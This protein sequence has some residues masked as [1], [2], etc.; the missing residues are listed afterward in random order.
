[1]WIVRLNGQGFLI[2]ID[3]IP[4]TVQI[5]KGIAQFDPTLRII[6]IFL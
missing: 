3:G 1:M 2:G 4:K 6:G 5:K